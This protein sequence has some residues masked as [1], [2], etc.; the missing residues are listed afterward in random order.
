[1]QTIWSRDE[2]RGSSV[3]QQ[4]QC[5][6]LHVYSRSRVYRIAGLF[7]GQICEIHEIFSREINPL[8]GIH[9]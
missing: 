6:G 5:H 4:K 1:M 8:Y 2:T 9:S 7:R 3:A